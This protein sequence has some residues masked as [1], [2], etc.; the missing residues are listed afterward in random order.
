MDDIIFIPPRL[1]SVSIVGEINR[2]GIYELKQNETLANLITMASGLKITAYLDRAQIDRI[3]PF[4]DR[5]ELGMDRMFTDVNLE[6]ILKSEDGFPLQD[7]DQI[8]I[9]SVLDLRP[10][11]V[12]LNGAVTRPGDYD[13][14]E[15][16]K[17]SELIKKAD[18]LLGDAYLDR[19]D[20][21]RIKSDLTEE[22]IKLDLKKVLDGNLDHD[23]DLKGQDRV[24]IYGMTEMVPKAFVTIS[25]HVKQPGEYPLQ[26]NMTLYDLIFK[27]GGY[28]DQEFKKMTYLNRAELVRVTNDGSEK[29]IIPFNLARVLNKQDLALVSLQADDAIR[30]YSMVE[31]RGDTR[32]VSI[33]GHVKR[34]GRYELFEENMTL[35]DLIFKAGG[36]EDLD[37]KC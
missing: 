5:A 33:T 19:V 30:I 34:P 18:G 3:V 14:G 8:H 21:V 32:Y 22:L 6:Q 13:L 17:I 7:G 1:K 12:S 37:F 27:A 10:N 36:F 2:G 25:G 9:F 20:V 29:E 26:E 35:Y 31:I 16:L 15:S 23:I 24:R 4:E 11:V 28:L